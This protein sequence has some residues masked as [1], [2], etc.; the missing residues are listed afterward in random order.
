MKVRILNTE[1]I[2]LFS[3]FLDRIESE[4][5][6]TVPNILEDLNYTEELPVDVFLDNKTFKNRTELAGHIFNR[7]S[8]S[9]LQ[10]SDN[11]IGLWTWITLYY[12]DQV[13]PDKAVGRRKRNFRSNPREREAYI[14]SPSNYQ[15]YYRHLIAAPYSLYKNYSSSPEILSSFL[16][17]PIYEINEVYAQI[18]ASQE[19]ISNKS[20]VHAVTKLYYDSEK[21]QN[22][23]GAGSKTGGTPRRLVDALDQFILTFDLYS[24]DADEILSIL[25]REFDKFKN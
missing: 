13:C 15:R 22:K 21:E 19:Y 20:I 9:N 16:C 24:M 25:P 11:D 4:K 1:G 2:Q 18:G 14:L 17:T 12:F 3:S 7:F 5:N 10:T 23:T 8:E 6:V